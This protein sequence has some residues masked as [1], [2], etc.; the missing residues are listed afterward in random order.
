MLTRTLRA[1]ANAVSRR[2]QQSTLK[3]RVRL[4]SKLR[5]TDMLSTNISTRQ[6]LSLFTLQFTSSPRSNARLSKIKM[7]SSRV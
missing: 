1:S 6:F 7:F 4:R 5:H 2:M 3:L